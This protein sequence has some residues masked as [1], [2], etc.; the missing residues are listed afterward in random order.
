MERIKSKD[1]E[2]GSEAEKSKEAP[3]ECAWEEFYS[4]LSAEKKAKQVE[5][6]HD[7][8]NFYP[9]IR[10]AKIVLFMGDARY[11]KLPAYGE[12]DGEEEDKR[13]RVAENSK[14]VDGKAV[15]DKEPED[16]FEF[17]DY[18]GRLTRQSNY[19]A[20]FA[21]VS[22]I[23]MA[24]MLASKGERG[25]NKEFYGNTSVNKL[26]DKQFLRTV[27]LYY[28]LLSIYLLGYVMPVIKTLF[29]DDKDDEE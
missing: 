5:V 20:E 21:Y 23:L 22:D 26:I 19:P 8:M 16:E 6:E 28:G 7:F 15:K 14:T 25:G 13:V 12:E 18:L 4:P 9:M 10:K 3:S 17:P 2:G 24:D 1:K 27:R 11:L 29:Y